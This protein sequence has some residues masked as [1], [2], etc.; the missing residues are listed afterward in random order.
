MIQYQILQIN[1][2]RTVWQTVWR[3]INEIL[4]VEGLTF[5]FHAGEL[6]SIIMAQKIKARLTTK[7]ICWFFFV[8]TDWL[9]T[10][11]DTSK[12]KSKTKDK[13]HLQKSNESFSRIWRVKFENQELDAKRKQMF[14]RELRDS[15][16]RAVK[17]ILNFPAKKL[18]KIWALKVRMRQFFSIESVGKFC[19]NESNFP[20]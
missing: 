11:S 9:F 19:W 15:S 14:S 4:G 20:A 16:S 6:Y 2:T 18:R 10:V 8:I 5:I 3:I 1:I 17:K 13:K 12:G 7:C